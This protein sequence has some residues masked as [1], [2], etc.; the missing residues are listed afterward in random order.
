MGTRQVG[1]QPRGINAMSSRT[2]AAAFI[3]MLISCGATGGCGARSATSRG[4]LPFGYV[5][6]P[7]ANGQV[8]NGAPG[9]G[10]ALSENGAAEVALYV[11]GRY[12]RSMRLRDGR[13]DVA[14]VYPNMEDSEH[15]G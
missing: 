3:F 1:R 7:K 10:W 13:I 12:A 14:K 15:S 2:T 8:R 6:A 9:N 5:D 11:D 4:P